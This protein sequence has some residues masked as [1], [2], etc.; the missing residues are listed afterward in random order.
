[1]PM[2]A[3]SAIEIPRNGKPFLRTLVVMN[4]KMIFV[5][6]IPILNERICGQVIDVFLYIDAINE[7]FESICSRRQLM[8]EELQIAGTCGFPVFL[9]VMSGIGLFVPQIA[10]VGAISV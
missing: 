10:L 4:Q 8:A 6:A 2:I 1:M 5:E 9:F 3:E 7:E